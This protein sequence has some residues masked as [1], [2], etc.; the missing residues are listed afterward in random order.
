MKI[1][2]ILL[3]LAA[4]AVILAA[5]IV[6]NKR[7][8]RG[9]AESEIQILFS[10]AATD[11]TCVTEADLLKLPEPAQR[12]LRYAQVVGRNRTRY[13]RLKQWGRMRLEQNGPWVP[14]DAEEYYTVNPPG[15]IWFAHLRLYPLVTIAGRDRFTDG[16]G[17]MRVKLLSTVSVVNALGPEMDQGG[18]LRY[19]NEIMWFPTAYLSKYLDWQPIDSSSV[20][21]TMTY[22]G[23]S[24]SAILRIDAG[25]K[26]KD[27]ACDRYRWLADGYSLDKWS[28]PISHYGEMGGFRIPVGGGEGAVWHLPSGDYS[29]FQID[30]L[31][32]EYDTPVIF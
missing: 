5:V 13:V 6:V 11:T 23:T 14:V 20:R 30:S 2:R 10:K 7:S 31:T 24:V 12:Y 25:G 26:L 19:L 22:G 1:R 32:V 3:V 27:F 18:A 28:T 9:E 8:F 21:V 16:K 4:I 17:N 29:Y 15:F